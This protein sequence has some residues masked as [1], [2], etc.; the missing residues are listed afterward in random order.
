MAFVM[1][2][3]AWSLGSGGYGLGYEGIAG[4]VLTVEFDTRDN[5]TPLE[6]VNFD[7]VSDHI[8]LQDNGD[9]NNLPANPNNLR[10]IAPTEIKPGFPDV[11]DGATQDVQI[12]WTT[13][14]LQLIEV[15]VDGIL[16]LS[17]NADMI[18]SQF[19]GVTTVIW[20]W[21]GSTSAAFTNEQIVCIKTLDVDI[22]ADAT[23]CEGEAIADL[24]VIS[25]ISGT[26]NWYDNPS[27]VPS[28]GTGGTFSPSTSPGTYTYYSAQTD[29][30]FGCEGEPDSV[31]IIINPLPP[32]P[33]VTGPTTYCEGDIPTP[34]DAETS[35]GGGVTW[36]DAPPPATILSTL[37]SYNPSTVTPGVYNYY[38]TETAAGCEGPA[39]LVTVTI[40]PEPAPP[41]V[42]GDLVYCEG[43]IPTAL[44][45]AT[46]LGGTIEWYN[47]VGTLLGTGLSFVPTLVPGTFDIYV[48]E[49]A[50]GCGSAATIVTITVDA[51]P[52]VDIPVSFGICAGES[53]QLIAINNGY[54]LLWSTTE[55]TD[56]I[57]LTPPSDITIYITCTNPLCGFDEDSTKIYV[58]PLPN[59]V[60]GSDTAIGI[61]GYVELWA[62]C[63]TVFS[64][65][66]TPDPDDCITSNC[67][68]IYD[69]PD[70]ATAY[71]VKAMDENGCSN[72]DTV[73]VDITGKM[74]VFVPNVF[75]PNGDG[76]NDYVE[77]MGPRLFDF[78]FQIFDRFGKCVFKSIDQMEKWDGSIGG[79]AMAPQTFVYV[80]SGETILGEKI[81]IE[82]NVSIIK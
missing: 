78:K 44:T 37:D 8:S 30:L 57:N 43:D 10:G 34:L 14:A 31:K 24:T 53:V 45:T 50:L 21:T 70:Q 22:D 17:H 68:E 48:Y 74:E 36:Y 32:A 56:T 73:F 72:S 75:S 2:S 55:T 18:T 40:N 69:V 27:L 67:S 51:E 11:E 12:S 60:A 19:G 81:D 42:A 13:G 76:W 80:V 1:K 7:V 41:I 20:G 64:F 16:S 71:V 9:I 15:Y 33:I 52:L 79:S 63:S 6:V 62:T 5:H 38:V 58:Y 26:I 61:G 46:T 77:V 82:G 25:G 65:T 4:N 59:I 54:D 39:T 3:G 29:L 47:S 28:L 23:Y 35:F 49:I 66:W